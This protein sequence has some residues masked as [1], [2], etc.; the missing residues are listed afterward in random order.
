MAVLMLSHKLWAYEPLLSNADNTRPVKYVSF[1]HTILSLQAAFHSLDLLS[2][3]QLLFVCYV[4][5]VVRD[6]CELSSVLCAGF[7]L[8]FGRDL[9]CLMSRP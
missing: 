4:W 3:V 1:A 9:V 5:V 7:G 6:M 2:F 8:C